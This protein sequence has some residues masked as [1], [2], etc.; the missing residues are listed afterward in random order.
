METYAFIGNEDVGSAIGGSLASAGFLRVDDLE[1]ADA[2]ITF[3]ASQEALE[4]A[5]FETD[6]LIK[7]AQPGT[8][9]IDLSPS[10]PSF[11][12]ELEAVA[13]VSDLAF[14]EAPLAVL[15]PTRLDAFSDPENVACCL[16]G[17][18]DAVR[19]AVEFAEAIAGTVHLTGGSGSAQMAKAAYT[20][21][22]VSHIVSAIEAQALRSAVRHAPAGTGANVAG[23]AQAQSHL[24]RCVLAA[25]EDERFESAYTIDL[26]RADL[27]AALAAADDVDLILPQAESCQHLLELL[28]VIGG[29]DM[30]PAALVLL[31]GEEADCARHGLDWTR[32]E[33]A[34]GDGCDHGHDRTDED[35]GFD[36]DDYGYDEYPPS[37]FG[38]SAN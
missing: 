33:E 8:L 27:D 35:D 18:E 38:Y 1:R 28:A 13:T 25:V 17:E 24:G 23:P 10:T 20:L 36:D 34:F 3:C 32:A 7:R 29:S 19:A 37:G 30:S 5:Y 9:L 26:M 16:A 15:D 22:A 2:V 21:Q 4:D 12:R 31:Y 11:A 6:G 14:V